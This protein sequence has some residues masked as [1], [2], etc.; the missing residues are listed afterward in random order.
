[1]KI[2]ANW[3]LLISVLLALVSL[4]GCASLDQEKAS[5]RDG[6]DTH[7]PPG[8]LAVPDSGMG[9]GV[10]VLHPW[11]GLNGTIKDI[12]R[13]LASRGYVAFA[14]DLY[15]GDVAKTIAQAETLARRLDEHH[16]QASGDVLSALAYLTQRSESHHRGVVVIGFSLGAFYALESA[17]SAPE[18][19]HAVVLFYGTGG[20]MDFSK[21]S[22]SYLGHFASDDPYEP[23]ESVDWLRG[24]LEKAGRPATFYTY[25]GTGHWF[26]EPDVTAAYNPDAAALAWSR[27]YDFL[28]RYFAGAVEE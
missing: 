13:D 8:F 27:T 24:E 17:S 5:P 28:E 19:I 16:V 7:S 9:P 3:S 14:P 18:A 1:M 6:I 23:K 25:E 2:V 26:V 12:C 20:G 11:W 22:S 4:S 15:H 21:S 10:L